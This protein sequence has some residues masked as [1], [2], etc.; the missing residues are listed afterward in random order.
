MILEPGWPQVGATGDGVDDP[1]QR[2]APAWV[3]P[4]RSLSR[5]PRNGCSDAQ[6]LIQVQGTLRLA[7]AGHRPQRA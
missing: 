3:L 4:S 5:Q 1:R 7:A 2:A 6:M